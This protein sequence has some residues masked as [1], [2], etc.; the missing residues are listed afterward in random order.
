M[1]KTLFDRLIIPKTKNYKVFFNA[2][3]IMIIIIILNAG[4]ILI[5]FFF[6]SFIQYLKHFF[7]LQF[8]FLFF[9]KIKIDQIYIQIMYTFNLMSSTGLVIMMMMT[10]WNLWDEEEKNKQT[11]ERTRLYGLL[12]TLGNY[13]QFYILYMQVVNIW[14]APG[15]ISFLSC[16]FFFLYYHYSDNV[17]RM[18]HQ[19]NESLQLNKSIIRWDQNEFCT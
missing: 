14:F 5:A 11:N 13:L 17:S 9:L 4:P 6:S 18:F 16:L 19:L 15:R 3:N 8:C 7:F 2:L 10:I 12:E 1:R